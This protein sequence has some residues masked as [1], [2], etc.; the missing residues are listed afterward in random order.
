MTPV[1]FPVSVE[2]YDER[3]SVRVLFANALYM[4]VGD[5]AYQMVECDRNEPCPDDRKCYGLKLSLD[6]RYVFVSAGTDGLLRY[7][8]E[9]ASWKSIRPPSVPPNNPTI[10]IGPDG[11]LYAG[12]GQDRYST[13][14]TGLYVSTDDGESW[15]ERELWIDSA[16]IR[17]NI[18]E[19]LVTP[20]GRL[21]LRCQPDRTAL[22]ALY[23]LD[24]DGM[25]RRIKS[26]SDQYCLLDENICEVNKWDLT[27][28]R[29]T[30]QGY[31]FKSLRAPSGIEYR[32]VLTWPGNDTVVVIATDGKRFMARFYVDTVFVGTLD[33]FVYLSNFSYRPNIFPSKTGNERSLVISVAGRND[34]ISMSTLRSAP[35]SCSPERVLIRTIAT[36]RQGWG[37]ASIEGHGWFRFDTTAAVFLDTLLSRQALDNLQRDINYRSSDI[38]LVGSGWVI[39]VTASG[40]D[41]LFSAPAANRGLLI[42]A[43]LHEETN[44]LLVATNNGITRRNLSTG[45]VDTLSLAGWPQKDSGQFRT[46]YRTAVMTLAGRTFAWAERPEREESIEGEGL[47]EYVAGAWKKI[48]GATFGVSTGFWG[49]VSSDSIIVLLAWDTFPQSGTLTLATSILGATDTSAFIVDSG[50]TSWEGYR[51]AVNGYMLIHA[52]RG[53]WH[54]VYPR[55][56]HDEFTMRED[57]TLVWGLA[58]RFVVSTEDRG[59]F[60]LAPVFPT[61]S[62]QDNTASRERCP[63]P[64]LYPNPVERSLTM[65]MTIQ[66]CSERPEVY[67]IDALG[68]ITRTSVQPL[69]Q[70]AKIVHVQIPSELGPGLYQVVIKG[71]SCRHA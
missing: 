37:I 12:Y 62:T 20:K 70:A 40:Y 9:M 15:T 60:L 36:C 58:D 10:A 27:L 45:V 48:E 7:D 22:S 50:G 63:E 30:S 5:D 67:L 64:R 6:G 59:V 69:D 56:R 21:F 54:R 57:V 19:I 33:L 42:D 11:T 25:L 44:E 55:G 29:Y 24:S 43:D 34:R 32:R 17:G 28:I 13:S 23:Q 46:Y 38:L 35:I 8:R 51:T 18:R 1:R 47:Y 53:R 61:T 14:L 16:K 71:D 39:R 26:S 3:D 41:T 4:A 65:N 68:R 2:Q 66:A 52:G 49:S 31:S